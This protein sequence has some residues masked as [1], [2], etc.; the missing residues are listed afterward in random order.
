MEE[1][2]GGVGQPREEGGGGGEQHPREH[3]GRGLYG[4]RGG[5]HQQNPYILHRLAGGQR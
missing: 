5:G 2:G 3:E 1:R 4:A